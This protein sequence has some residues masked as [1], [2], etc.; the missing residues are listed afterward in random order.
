MGKDTIYMVRNGASVNLFYNK[1]DAVKLWNELLESTKKSKYV[2]A[3]DCVANTDEYKSF[4]YDWLTTW[5]E[6]DHITASCY[7]IRVK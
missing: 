3:V 5:G 2:S 1:E 7:A 4:H 6:I